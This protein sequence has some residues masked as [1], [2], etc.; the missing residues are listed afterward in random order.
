MEELLAGVGR[1][2]GGRHPALQTAARE[3]SALLESYTRAPPALYRRAVLGNIQSHETAGW[4]G[5][6]GSNES[7]KA[8][9]IVVP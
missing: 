6:R 8:S 5:L 9:G 7:Y 2:W 3:A 4:L 1:D